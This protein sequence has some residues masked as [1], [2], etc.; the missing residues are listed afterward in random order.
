VNLVYLD[1]S[2]LLK[3]LVASEESDQLTEVVN[4]S[5]TAGVRLVTSTLARVELNHARLS[6]ELSSSATSFET[7]SLNGLFDAFD[8]VQ[9]TE[10]ILNI[11]S[12]IPFRVTSLQAIHLAT[13]DVLRSDL[14]VLLSFDPDLLRVGKLMGL[15]ARTA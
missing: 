15:N 14:A 10:E 3:L 8:L 6:D 12:L 11:A 9:I 1:S 7:E 5:L 2:A 4:A 13:A